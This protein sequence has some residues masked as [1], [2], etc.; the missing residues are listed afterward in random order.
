M[1]HDMGLT[2]E[3]ASQHERFEVDS[4]NIARDFPRGHGI[5]QQDIDTV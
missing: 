5:A 2:P 1:F 4:A 3:Y